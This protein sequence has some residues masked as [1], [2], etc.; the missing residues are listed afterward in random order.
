MNFLMSLSGK[1]SEPDT[2]YSLQSPYLDA[3]IPNHHRRKLPIRS[4][5][6]LLN[7]SRSTESV[8]IILNI[9]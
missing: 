7:I 4:R 5:E 9:A 2:H 1:I 8:I 6:L 3:T